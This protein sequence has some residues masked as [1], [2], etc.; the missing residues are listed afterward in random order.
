MYG[1]G[2]F[3]TG[4]GNKFVVIWRGIC[5]RLQ[6]YRQDTVTS[7][8]SPK[9]GQ[10]QGQV[11]GTSCAETHRAP[12]VST[13]SPQPQPLRFGGPLFCTFIFCFVFFFPFSCH[14]S[15]FCFLNIFALTFFEFFLVAWLPAASLC[16]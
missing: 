8:M 15:D 7:K 13:F 16:R 14:I 12:T 6:L 2:C 9:Q 1:L 11:S 4:F 10:G 3:E 5:F